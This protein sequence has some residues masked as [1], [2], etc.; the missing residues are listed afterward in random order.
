VADRAAG[1]GGSR[2][3]AWLYRTQAEYRAGLTEFS[4]MGRSGNEPVLIAIPADCLPPGWTPEPDSS[5]TFIDMAQLGR[6]P[7]RIIA[8]VQEFCEC[9]QGRR[10]RYVGETSWPG[11][12]AAEVREAGRHE[13]LLNLAFAAA[14]IEI[15]CPYNA[16]L[17]PPAVIA[18]VSATHP[19]MLQGG[20][21]SANAAYLPPADYLAALE[22]PP[23]PPADATVLAFARDLRPVRALVSAVASDAGLAASRCTD[24]VIAVSEVAANSLRHA[25]GSG[26]VRLWSA[27]AELLCQVEDSGH[28]TDPLA[29]HRRPAQEAGGGQG[30][31]LANQMCD[32]AEISTSEHGTA[33][34]L[35]MSLGL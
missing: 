4:G 24:L 25:A 16:A 18:G 35:H 22:G 33:V 3:V 12:S 9:H 11:R 7:A 32:L 20:A 6:N 21:V 34:R 13:A 15:L 28:I 26:L 17:L 2:H 10:I 30:L 31:W 5:Q 19:L 29:G 14:D 8:A 27:D 23:P 1:K